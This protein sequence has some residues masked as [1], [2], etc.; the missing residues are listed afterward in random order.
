MAKEVAKPAEPPKPVHIGGESI[1]DRI[2][3]HIKKII[4]FIIVMSVVLSVVFAVRWWQHRGEEQQTE[5][6][7]AVLGVAERPLAA[8]DEKP[9]PK[10]PKYASIKDRASAVLDELAKQDTDRAGHAYKAGL[11]VDADKLDDAIAEYRAGQT[12]EGVEGVLCREGLGLALEQKALAEKDPAAR[13]KGLE[14]ALAAFT[15]MQPDESGPR[16]AYALYH[17]GRLLQKLGKRAEAKTA[18]EK[19]KDAGPPGLDILELIEKRL[20]SLGAA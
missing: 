15:S 17:Q 9:D 14:E 11:L 1:V 12:A 4:V 8:P 7:S 20:A 2:L 5:K 10:N 6:L 3:P 18:F 13:Q 19:A 16:R